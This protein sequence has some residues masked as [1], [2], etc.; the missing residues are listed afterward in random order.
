MS[1]IVTLIVACDGWHLNPPPQATAKAADVNTARA[2][3][4][5]QGW[6]FLPHC[7]V[8]CPTC[9]KTRRTLD[10]KAL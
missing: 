4:R 2:T 5:R 3:L 1:R 7:R 10:S 9:V 6:T 8:Y